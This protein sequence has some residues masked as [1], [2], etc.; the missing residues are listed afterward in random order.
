[1]STS[2]QKAQRSGS[3]SCDKYRTAIQNTITELQLM[4]SEVPHVVKVAF[5]QHIDYLSR[6]LEETPYNKG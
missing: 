1:M 6:I 4:Y 2:N 3:D 5:E